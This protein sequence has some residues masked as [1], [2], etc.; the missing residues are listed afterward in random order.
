MST[1]TSADLARRRRILVADE[2]P[3]VVEFIIQTLREDGHA[4]FHAYDGLSAT[5]LAF[6]LGE[7]VHLVISNT[8]VQ[9]MPGIELI[10]MLR[11]R[12]PNLPIMYIA[13]IDRSTPAIEAKLPR[14]VPILREP[15]TA[16][17]L[18]A[19]VGPLLE[20]KPSLLDIGR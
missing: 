12:L 2:D 4:V 6:T 7:D 17:Q 10:Y 15:F 3:K 5:E 1:P 20:G 9:G 13:N 8:R 19:L 18:R 16:E 14:D 11:T